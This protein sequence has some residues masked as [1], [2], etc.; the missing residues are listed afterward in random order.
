M[1]QTRNKNKAFNLIR[2]LKDFIA[3]GKALDKDSSILPLCGDGSALCKP[4]DIPNS[5]DQLVKLYPH[6]I[7]SN[8]VGGQMKIRS[9]STIAQLKHQP[10]YVKQ[11]LLHECVHIN[12][13]HFGPEEGI[14][15]GWITGSHPAFT[16]HNGMRDDLASMMGNEVPGIKWALYP[17]TI[18]YT[19]KSDSVK[20]ATMGVTIQVT[21]KQG[22]DPNLLRDTIAHKW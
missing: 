4:Q 21:K 20:L 17:K 8:N 22:M 10:S 6:R 15:M 5:Q 19:R 13:A 2:S 12:N 1:F 7:G 16:H 11:Y 3:A 14:V 9:S 18:F